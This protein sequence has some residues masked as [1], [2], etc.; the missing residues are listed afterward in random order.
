MNSFNILAEGK[1]FRYTYK[2]LL[3]EFYSSTPLLVDLQQ[4]SNY[5][6]GQYGRQDNRQR[7]HV[8]ASHFEYCLLR[9]RE[10]C[11]VGNVGL[12]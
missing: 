2:A 1:K 4:E 3:F 8:D 10:K 9:D 12:L 6:S 7:R 5:R 11:S